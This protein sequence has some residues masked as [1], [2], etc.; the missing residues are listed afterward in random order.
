V[1][2]SSKSQLSSAVAAATL[3]SAT[4][5]A[6]FVAGK[7][8][9]DALYLT[10]LD[11]TTLPA[12]VALTSAFSI[13]LVGVSSRALRRLSTGA[14]VSLAF[15]AS[16]LLLF[17]SWGLT[18]AAP[19]G[20]AIAVYLLISG[21]GPILGS[22]FWLIATERFDPRTAKKRFGQIAGGGTIGGLLGGLL[23]ERVAAIAGV[24]AMLPVLA[25]LNLVCAWQIRALSRSLDGPA[26]PAAMDISPELAAAAPRS[27]LRVL[28]EAPYLRNLAAIVFLGTLGAALL[29][30]V[31]K[32]EVVGAFGRGDLLMRFFAG[33]YAATSLITFVFQTSASRLVLEKL[34]LAVTTA[35]PSLALFLGSLAGLLA[36]GLGSTVVARSGESVF[37][38][39]LFRSGYELFYTPIP[40]SEKRAAKSLIDVGFDRLGDAIGGGLVFLALLLPATRQTPAILTLALLAA[41]AALGVASRLNRGYVHTLERSL[42]NRA[43]ELDLSDAED[44]TTR[45]AMIRSLTMIRTLSRTRSRAPQTSPNEMARA[46]TAPAED[47]ARPVRAAPTTSQSPSTGTQDAIDTDLVDIMALRSR[48]KQRVV[49]VLERDLSLEPSLVPHVIPLLAWDPVANEAVNALRR[50]AEERVGELID[51]LIDPNQP[52]AAR[53]RLARVFAAC[54]SQRA[55]DGLLLGL[56]DLRFEVRFQCARSLVAILEKNPRVHVDAAFVFEVVRREVAVG[57]PVWEA[58]RLLHGPEEGDPALFLDAF[59]R[60]RASRSLAHVFTLLSLVLP[61]EPLRIAFRGLHTD[62]QNLKGTALEYLEGVLPPAIR[63]RLWPFLDDSRTARHRTTRSRD[64]ILA[65]LLRSNQSMVI[66]L[67]ALQEHHQAE[68]GAAPGVADA[69]RKDRAPNAP[70]DTP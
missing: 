17:A 68:R 53:R 48:D 58:H 1:T 26:H 12:M 27:G 2:T 43:V 6:Q 64:E 35:T 46:T 61:P 5:T 15:L 23:S 55:V 29:D 49:T 52:F 45:T 22:G 47:T 34:G 24:P 63:D 3:A 60:D 8:T 66:N 69:A 57:R 21:L 18:I 19:T 25:A 11:V 9:R 4:V 40:A 10:E 36:P 59:V 62:D 56:D 39:S 13:V 38:G 41:A 54:V 44:I 14:F 50:V 16:S 32:L 70:R 37:R 42:L 33:Y 67:E 20:A 7:A 28:A 30:Y 51:A 31:F 65:E